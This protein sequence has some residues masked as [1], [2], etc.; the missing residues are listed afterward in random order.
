MLANL[1]KL[2]RSSESEN[3]AA[4][5]VTEDSPVESRRDGAAS[6]EPV[7]VIVDR[8]D[9]A[10]HDRPPEA[11]ARQGPSPAAPPA[12]AGPAARDDAESPDPAP[13]VL[14]SAPVAGQPAASELPAARSD[15]QPPTDLPDD[16]SDALSHGS[17]ES[18]SPPEPFEELDVVGL[19][20]AI[21]DPEAWDETTQ[22]GDD[23][24]ARGLVDDA[25]Q[26]NGSDAD[27]AG[28]TKKD[29]ELEMESLLRSWQEPSDG[30][31]PAT[32]T[33]DHGH[34]APVDAPASWWRIDNDGY[35]L[36]RAELP[37]VP[38]A[39]LARSATAALGALVASALSVN[40]YAE[41]VFAGT[42]SLI[43]RDDSSNY[44]WR[45]NADWSESDGRVE[46]LEALSTIFG[47]PVPIVGLRR[48]RARG[49]IR[50]GVAQTP[51]LHL[52]APNVGGPEP[53][54]EDLL[55]SAVPGVRLDVEA[56]DLRFRAVRISGMA[57]ACA[58]DN[59]E[60]LSVVDHWLDRLLGAATVAG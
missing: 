13:D 48:L 23:D 57:V 46:L 19:L 11:P 28:A 27:V 8:H 53:E 29:E 55:G 9:G 12:E 5:G 49:D 34:R 33:D 35:A 26:R 7:Q 40:E 56:G 10:A 3:E 31:P 15:P 37:D 2:L 41:D 60:A 44:A 59:E 17:A 16:P 54:W 1:F 30:S 52:S 4:A 6:A 51:T 36:P 38:L 14:P 43:V 32:A 47:E 42:V 39:T 24:A 50:C 25:A 22:G 58:V 20:V 45:I 18:S 21:A